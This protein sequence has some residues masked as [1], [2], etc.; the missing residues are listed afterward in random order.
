MEIQHSQM[1]TSVQ[2]INN[3]INI[4]SLHDFKIRLPGHAFFVSVV[5]AFSY[6]ETEVKLKLKGDRLTDFKYLLSKQPDNHIFISG[7]VSGLMVFFDAEVVNI[8][9]D[10][11]L[12]IK[13]PG[14]INYIDNREERFN[15]IEA[16][17]DS[18]ARRVKP[19]YGSVTASV[20][21]PDNREDADKPICR[22]LLG[23]VI[24]HSQHG[25]GVVFDYQGQDFTFDVPIGFRLEIQLHID[26]IHFTCGGQLRNVSIM[27]S[28]PHTGKI[29][30]GFL[31]TLLPAEA[32]KLMLMRSFKNKESLVRYIAEK[33]VNA[34]SL[35]GDTQ[36]I[37]PAVTAWELRELC[38]DHFE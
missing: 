15:L 17:E 16:Q 26:N 21:V 8:Y 34:I 37:L 3:L 2:E 18:L 32:A 38:L 9:E 11:T 30:A 31:L 5:S 4:S 24:D 22:E 23:N 20:I 14:R 13:Y 29:R 35:K 27:K 6:E 28:G 33:V 1:L 25:I 36:E 10:N 7:N 19:E 12:F